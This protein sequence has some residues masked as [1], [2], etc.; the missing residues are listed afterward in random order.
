MDNF[1][2]IDVERPD[3]K[4]FP[5]LRR[6]RA[7]EAVLEPGDVLWL[8]RFYWH[9]VHQL[10]APSENISLNFCTCQFCCGVHHARADFPQCI[11]AF[12]S[13]LPHCPSIARCAAGMQGSARRE[14]KT[15]CSACAIPPYRRRIPSLRRLSMP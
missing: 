3:V 15:S 10:D 5:S 11:F 2:M 7:L 14:H 8:P 1:A 9:Y 6:A 13:V 4:R 12:A